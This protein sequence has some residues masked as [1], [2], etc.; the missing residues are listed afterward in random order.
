MSKL[1]PQSIKAASEIAGTI[2]AITEKETITPVMVD[3]I[4]A[5]IDLAISNFD[6]E[7]L[8][9]ELERTSE[10]SI[11]AKLLVEVAQ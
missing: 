8:R 1:A 11:L 5:V 4:T 10:D 6:I 3:Y 2:N 7:R 9:A